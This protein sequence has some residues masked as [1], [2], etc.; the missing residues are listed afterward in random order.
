MLDYCGMPVTALTAGR[1]GATE[2][3]ALASLLSLSF[4]FRPLYCHPG[5]FLPDITTSI[6]SP[7]EKRHEGH[8]KES[9]MRKNMYF[10]YLPSCHRP[11]GK[12][13][14]ISNSSISRFFIQFF[15]PFFYPVSSPAF[16][17]SYLTRSYPL[18]STSHEFPRRIHRVT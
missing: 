4:S 10:C 6:N 13:L 15:F 18:V 16:L 12:A 7:H 11:C 1:C 3:P 2:C 5:S 9:L 14:A 8:K 17:L